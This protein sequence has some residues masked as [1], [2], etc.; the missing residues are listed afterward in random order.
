VCRDVAAFAA[1]LGCTDIEVFPS[2]ILGGDG[3]RE[4]FL[5]ARRG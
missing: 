5:G 4:F 1:G 2:K 3:N